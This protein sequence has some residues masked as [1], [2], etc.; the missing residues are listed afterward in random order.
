MEKIKLLITDNNEKLLKLNVELFETAFDDIIESTTDKDKAIELLKSFKPDILITDI[1]FNSDEEPTLSNL[2][3]IAGVTIA[4]SARINLPFIKIIASS[5]YRNDDLVFQK[6]LEK[7][8]YD[9]FHTKGTDG[10]LK[11]YEKLRNEVFV[12]KSGLIPKLSKFFAPTN[13]NWDINKSIYRLLH[14]NYTRSENLKYINQTIDYYNSFKEM[15]D[16]NNRAMLDDFFKTYAI[17]NVT[18]EERANIKE[19]FYFSPYELPY[20]N[21]FPRRTLYC[22]KNII[23]DIWNK[24]ISES[25][26]NSVIDDVEFH[27]KTDK[28]NINFRIIQ[29][30]EFDFKKFISSNKT[31]Y[32]YK[33]IRN[34]GNIVIQSG[35]KELNIKTGVLNKIKN[36]VNGTKIDLNLKIIPTSV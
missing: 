1:N 20:S 27:C 13:Y 16:K 36:Y 2:L 35:D 6:I 3:S 24:I 31:F 7:D 26:D 21:K 11:Q 10:L 34:Y 30:N 15:L 19:T 28:Y 18:D 8:W 9:E 22:E 14:T 33:S 29:P 17:R 4:R 25:K 32:I 5:G 23:L 12:F